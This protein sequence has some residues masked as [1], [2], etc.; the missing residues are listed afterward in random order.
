MTE[1]NRIGD[2][3][4]FQALFETA[5]PEFVPAIHRKEDTLFRKGNPERPVSNEEG[6]KIVK[7]SQPPSVFKCMCSGT[8]YRKRSAE[9]L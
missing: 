8:C 2:V 1:I 9:D 6:G 3:P 7:S 5:T 4:R